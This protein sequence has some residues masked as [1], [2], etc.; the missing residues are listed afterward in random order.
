MLKLTDTECR[1]AKPRERPY[2]LRDGKGLYLEIKPSGVKAWRYRFEIQEGETT[3]ESIFAIGTYGVAH[4]SETPEEARAR[5][6]DGR[7]TLEEARVEREKARA[8]VK[9]GIS[10]CSNRRMER[11]KLQKEN[12]T[13]FEGIAREWL[14]L[15]DWEESTKARRLDMMNRVIFPKIGAMPMKKV[16]P[17]H[18]LDILTEAAAKNG[19]S[20]AAEARR[21]M[22]GVF[23]LAVSTLRADSDPVY[24]VRRALPPNKTQHKRPLSD[25]EIGQ[26]LRD[27]EGH[28]GRFETVCAFKLMW[29]T[30]CRPNEAVEA[31]W[32]EFDLDAARWTI[33]SGRMKKRR[34]HV[35]PLPAQAV[36]MLRALHGVT[37]GG[38][39]LFPHRDTKTKPMV[40]ASFRQMLRVLGWG[41]KF[42]PHAARATGS[43]RLNEMGFSPDAIE[44]QLAHLDSNSVRRSYNHAEY[45][46]QRTEMMQAWANHL[47]AI[48]NGAKVIPLRAA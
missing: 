16:T 32:R 12:A 10:P 34:E 46:S 27:V 29:W 39:F 47:D 18:V 48:K 21:T 15:K 37:G 1:K 36:A 26:L 42:S 45:F 11:A 14:A 22:S 24:P 7:F 6:A 9:Q 35:C 25:S 17:A 40:Q 4:R 19:P 43:T 30:L 5:R 8:L 38:E 44:R 13:T 41:G 3:K 33:S 28:G 31:E 23:E 20:V 2:K